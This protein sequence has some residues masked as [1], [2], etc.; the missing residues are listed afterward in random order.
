M[1]HFVEYSKLFSAC[2]IIDY[3][4]KSQSDDPLLSVE[5]VLAKHESILDEWDERHLGE[6]VPKEN[7]FREVVSGETISERPEI[8]KVLR[9]IESP[10]YKAIKVVDPQRLTRGDLEDIGRLMKILKFTKT[11]IITPERIYDLNDEYDWSAFEA[12]LKRGNDYLKY[13]KKILNRG[14]ILSVSQGNFIASIPPYG[15]D[16][17]WKTD[18][19]KKY[20]TLEP[21]KERADIVRLIFEW[22]VN[23]NIGVNR[24]CNRLDE[25]NVSAPVGEHWSAAAVKTMLSNDHYIGKVRWNHRKTV[26]VV[27]DG[28][29][30]KTR[31]VSKEGEY[32]IFDGKHEAII[33]EALFKAAQEKRGRN[34]R[35]KSTTKVRNPLAGLVYCRCGRAMSLRFYKNPDGSQRSA[36]RLLCDDQAHCHT[37]SC[38]YSEA[39]I[40]VKDVLAQK[41]ADFELLLKNENEDEAAL[42]ES[43]IESLEKKLEALEKKELLQWEMQSDPDESKRM[44]TQIFQQ[45]NV[46]LLKEKE[47]LQKALAKAYSEKPNLVNY[48]EKLHRFQEALDALNNDE[49]SAEKQNLLLKDCIERIEYSREAPERLKKEPGEKKGERFKSSGGYWSNPPATFDFELKI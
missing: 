15:Y 2:E 4:R 8:N 23:E 22:Y 31:P 1:Y 30:Y 13:T 45:L 46:K 17:V 11:Y 38:L 5:E 10:K 44:P 43:L 40:K 39:L 24:I 41:I 47:K 36:P 37:G 9:L 21:N 32:L 6:T 27:E 3:L 42:R 35:A 33:S 16:K 29:I 12:E 14:R 7:R 20:P 25:L 49:V 34:H 19:K 18:G 48:K 28:N 26:E